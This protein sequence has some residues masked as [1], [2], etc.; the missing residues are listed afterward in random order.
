M[1]SENYTIEPVQD[2]ILCRR[3]DSEPKVRSSIILNESKKPVFGLLDLKEHVST[4]EVVVANEA[5]PK[6]SVGT[7]LITMW[8]QRDGSPE[9]YY[10]YAEPVHGGD[11]VLYNIRA[12]Y[13]HAILRK[14]N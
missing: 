3:V 2:F 7:R 8:Q 4:F 14:S 1:T 10:P 11:E 13:V 12:S 9:N 5:F 6:Y